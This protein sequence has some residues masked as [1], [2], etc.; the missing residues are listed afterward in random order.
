MSEQDA[1]WSVE[2]MAEGNELCLLCHDDKQAQSEE[3]GIRHHAP[4]AEGECQGCHDPHESQFAFM[5]QGPVNDA[6]ESNFCFGCHTDISG[7]AKKQT[8]HGA[9]E[10]G[11]LMCHQTH[12]GGD[13]N[14]QQFAFH[15]TDNTPALCL[16]CHDGEDPQLLSSHGGQPFQSASCTGC[17]NPHG[18]DRAK[19][20]HP[21]AHPPFAEKQCEVCHEAP[22]QGKV[23]LAEAGKKELCFFCHAEKQEQISTAKVKHTYFDVYD[24]CTTCHS[25]HA[26]DQPRWLKKPVRK[27][28]AGCHEEQASDEWF[29]HR[30]IE[31][32]DSC[33]ICHDPHASDFRR[34][35]RADVN[36][37]YLT[38]HAAVSPKA[39]DGSETVTLFGRMKLPADLFDGVPK[40]P[41][42]EG[43]T[44]GHPMMRHPVSGENNL[45]PELGEMRC[46]SCHRPHGEKLG[47]NLF[48]KE[49]KGSSALCIQ[50]HK[51]GNSRGK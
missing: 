16:G 10:M 20:I 26:T 49:G 2:L 15:L 8:L 34:Y 46:S 21:Q 33:A 24:T 51:L 40:I 30:P 48:V 50:C 37:L 4:V 7:L 44:R 9:L 18:S 13:V 1:Q 43:N 19:L 6:S 38:C 31:L 22:Q 45:A 14:E 27:L 32:H 5:L 39:E 36:G 17:H 47:K 29:V 23:V 3:T 25:P 12:K 35:L 42:M 41:L 11:C 28:C